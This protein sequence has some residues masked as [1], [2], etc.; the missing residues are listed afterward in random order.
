MSSS[1]TGLCVDLTCLMPAVTND[2]W[3]YVS[4]ADEWKRS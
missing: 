2:V 4:L 1:G 3:V